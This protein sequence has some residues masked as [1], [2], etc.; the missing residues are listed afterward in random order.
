MR[1]APEALENWLVDSIFVHFPSAIRIA[2]FY[3][4]SYFYACTYT[5]E[6]LN[7]IGDS[8]TTSSDVA[9]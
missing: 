6:R 4:L 5:F 3:S 1:F 2:S 8:N 9:V 7:D